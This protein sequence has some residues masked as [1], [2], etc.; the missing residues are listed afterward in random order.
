MF[1]VLFVVN[2]QLS[3]FYDH[4]YG[5]IHGITWMVPYR[6]IYIIMAW[7]IR[8]GMIVTIRYI[9]IYIMSFAIWYTKHYNGVNDTVYDGIDSTAY[10]SIYDTVYSKLRL[11]FWGI[12]SRLWNKHGCDV[13]GV[14]SLRVRSCK[15]EY[16]NL[17]SF[18]CLLVYLSIL[19]PSADSFF[20]NY[21]HY[22]FLLK[23]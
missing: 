10:W 1:Y 16:F 11:L 5:I 15:V 14:A 13:I 18:Y 20:S 17:Y 21:Y 6:I 9:I 19:G 8:Y 3:S 12:T 22:Y 4:F 7:T 23:I 2:I